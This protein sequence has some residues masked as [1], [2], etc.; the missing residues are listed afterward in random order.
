MKSLSAY[1]VIAALA[2]A[3]SLA[4]PVRPTN[5]DSWK[6]T[7]KNKVLLH[8]HG[9]RS[10]TTLLLDTLHVAESDT[11]KFTYYSD[12]G[13][14]KTVTRLFLGSADGRTI[15]VSETTGGGM[16][17]YGNFTLSQM[18]KVCAFYGSDTLTLLYATRGRYDTAF[19]TPW[20]MV[21]VSTK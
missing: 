15:M 7:I 8:D 17:R 16:V 5:Y 19:C 1:L 21:R 2:N 12:H 10:D 3:Y 18:K 6:L 11:I 20:A 4:L 14:G 9:S 13:D